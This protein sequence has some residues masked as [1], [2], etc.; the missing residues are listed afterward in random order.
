MDRPQNITQLW[1]FLGTITYYQT[2]WPQ[3]SHLLAPLMELTGKGQFVWTPTCQKAFDE[4][5]A[6]IA[7]DAILAYPNHNKPFEIYTNASDYQIGTAIIQKGKPVAYWSGKLNDAQCIYPTVE[8]ELLAVVMCFKEFHSMLLGATIAKLI[9][10]AF[11]LVSL[12][13]I[14][15]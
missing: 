2:M 12:W 11:R 1:S 4:M 6:I 5:K 14:K 8:K 13:F 15:I 3:C 9:Q 7:G 10:R